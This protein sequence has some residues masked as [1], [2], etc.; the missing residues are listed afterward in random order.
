MVRVPVRV[1]RLKSDPAFAAVRVDRLA[2]PKAYTGMA[3]DQV[4]EFLKTIVAPTLRRHAKTPR[5]GV[6]IAV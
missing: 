5:P 2:D 6:E 1:A 4:D 3:A